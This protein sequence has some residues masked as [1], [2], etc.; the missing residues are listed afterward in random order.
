MKQGMAEKFRLHEIRPGIFQLELPTPYPIGPVYVYLIKKDPITLIDV[1][2]NSPESLTALQKQLQHLG[3]KIN[4]IELLLIT[5]SHSDHYGAAQTLKEEGAKAVAIHPRDWD[6]VTDRRD[7]YLRMKPY[8]AQM[9]MPSDY[10][11]YFV[12]FIVWETPYARD[13][14]EVQNLRDGELLFWEDL[15]L[16]VMHTPGHSPGHV[17]LLCPKEKWAIT[18]D[19]IFTHIT[20]DPILD[21]TPSGYRTPSMPLHMESLKRFAARG[22]TTF[23]PGH[24]ERKGKT[25]AALKEMKKRMKHKRENYLEILAKGPLTP[26]QLMRRLYPTSRKGEAFVLLSEVIGRLDLLEIDEAVI[27]WREAGLIFYG[28]KEGKI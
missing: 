9:G 11:E 26:F 16:E 27:S 17:V 14:E 15:K 2:V 22:I 10:L 18:G 25:D 19:F 12:K 24:L 23:F 1:G 8:L 6:K 4:Q 20:P 7:Y 13:L 3:V 28:L 21:I 5:H